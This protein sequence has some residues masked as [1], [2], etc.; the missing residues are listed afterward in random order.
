MAGENDADQ[1]AAATAFKQ[2]G[3]R[4]LLGS[5]QESKDVFDTLSSDTENVK[6]YF[7]H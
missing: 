4:A 2:K 6:L 5:A 3:I 7:K 1:L